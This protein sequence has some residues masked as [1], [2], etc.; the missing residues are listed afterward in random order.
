MASDLD[1]EGRFMQHAE[2]DLLRIIQAVEK[3]PLCPLR[4]QIGP[5]THRIWGILELLE[6]DS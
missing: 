1:L 2:Y 3:F 4:P 6:S 5:Q